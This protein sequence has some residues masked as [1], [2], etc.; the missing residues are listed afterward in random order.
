MKGTIYGP[1][2]PPVIQDKP[3]VRTSAPSPNSPPLRMNWGGTSTIVFDAKGFLSPEIYVSHRDLLEVSKEAPKLTE[4]ARFDAG[5]A[6]ANSVTLDKIYPLEHSQTFLQHLRQMTNE[7][8]GKGFPTPFEHSLMNTKR[9]EKERLRSRSSSELDCHAIARYLLAQRDDDAG[10]LISN[11]KLQKLVYYAQGFSLAL[12][13]RPLFPESI[14]AWAHGP[15]VPELYQEYE[16]YG[17]GPLPFP[18]GCDFSRFDTQTREL[19]DEVYGTY[20]QFSAW[21]LRDMTH[22]EPPWCDTPVGHEIRHD[23]LSNF[24]ATRTFSESESE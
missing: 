24:F 17:S 22:S 18:S 14:E 16:S 2:E 11:R 12:Y 4:F 15:V 6:Y 13:D 19:L 8:V 1:Y 20:G 9:R 7:T 23:S 3:S 21:K 10:D 5:V